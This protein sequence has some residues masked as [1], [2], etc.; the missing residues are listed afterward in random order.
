MLNRAASSNAQF[1]RQQLYPG[2]GGN[3]KCFVDD[4]TRQHHG[5][6]GFTRLANFQVLD[7]AIFF[8]VIY[9]FKIIITSLIFLLKEFF[10][11]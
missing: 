9:L 3:D 2:R 7:F 10:I 11:I 1:Y 8:V 6:T 5:A 4:T